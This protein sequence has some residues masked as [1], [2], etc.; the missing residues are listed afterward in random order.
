MRK[1]PYYYNSELDRL[2]HEEITHLQE[3]KLRVQ[4]RY[5]HDNSRFYRKKFKDAG[6]SA[7]DIRTLHDLR[8]LPIFLTK[9]VERHIAAESLE[10]YGHP[11]GTHLCC[12]IEDV[13]LVGTTSGTTG[14]PTF[15]YIFTKKDIETILENGWSRRFKSIGIQ[16]GDRVAFF[17]AL[18]VY[19]TTGSLYALRAVGAL[20]IDIDARAG[21][22]MLLQF[23]ELTRPSYL[24]CTPSLAEFLIERCP[25]VLHRE[26]GDLK[27]SGL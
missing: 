26:V 27:F 10:K 24:A 6:V 1:E 21:T 13:T 3:K 4:I 17:F 19:A 23:I 20:P 8:K 18:G 25:K 2:S 7:E 14:V 9:D 16:R 12:P 15:S 22:D 11:F 5:C